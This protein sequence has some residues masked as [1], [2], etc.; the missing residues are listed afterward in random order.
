MPNRNWNFPRHS[1]SDRLAY[2]LDVNDEIITDI[3]GNGVCVCV[4]WHIFS[5]RFFFGACK[6]FSARRLFTWFVFFFLIS[7]A[8]PPV[9]YELENMLMHPKSGTPKAIDTLYVNQEI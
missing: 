6:K 8:T 5:I 2:D 4:G 1:D 9:L 3:V 7:A